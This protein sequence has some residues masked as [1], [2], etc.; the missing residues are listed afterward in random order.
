MES[1]VKDTAAANARRRR[2]KRA[3]TI[4]GIVAVAVAA[5][6]GI[7]RWMTAGEEHTDDAQ[8]DAD[9]V[10]VSAQV[11]GVVAKLDVADHQK[12]EA[13]APM[14]ELDPTDLDIEVA[15]T[16]ADLAAANAAV[17]AARAQVAIVTSTA[18]GGLSTAKAQ[19]NGAAASVR[20]AGD[21]VRAATAMVAKAKADLANAESEL[22]KTQQLAAK[23]AITGREVERAQQVRDVA[24]AGLDAA[25]AQLGAAKAQQGLA[26]SKVAEAKAHVEQSSPVDAQVAAAQAQ[27]DLAIA[28]A[29]GAE[30]AH[31]KA[32]RQR[33]FATV[34]APIAGT[35]SR[36]AAH[37][38]Q[39]V[40]PGQMLVMVV[41]NDSYIVANFK[42]GQIAKMH[43]GDAVDIELDAFPDDTYHGVVEAIA[44]ATGA[45]FS[46]IPPDNAT[47]NFVKV[48]QRVPVKIKWRNQPSADVRPGL[49]AEVTVHVK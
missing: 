1:S 14:F 24:A 37:P 4:L 36:L 46:L 28:R 31:K 32:E 10:P 29:Q 6:W 19:V 17:E 40:M 23:D 22:A 20:S 44:P 38:G 15:R 45:R 2:A 7:H 42:E 47:G 49:S 39:T 26:S 12:V 3:Y 8:V 35:V 41:P 21:Q 27:L 11:G 43:P 33:G 13:G 34:T 9:V 18:G 25:N 30:V 5:V 48:V 16:A